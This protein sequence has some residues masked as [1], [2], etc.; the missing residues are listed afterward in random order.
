MSMLISKRLSNPTVMTIRV[1]RLRS[2]PCR[3][4]RRATVRPW[5]EG[6]RSGSIRGEASS[7]ILWCLGLDQ[8]CICR[9]NKTTE[10][11]RVPGCEMSHHQLVMG[12][13]DDGRGLVLRKCRLKMRMGPKRP[14]RLIKEGWGVDQHGTGK[15]ERFSRGSYSR[16]INKGTRVYAA[17]RRGMLPAKSQLKRVSCSVRRASRSTWVSCMNLCMPWTRFSSGK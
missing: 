5:V 13:V 1:V 7:D 14:I 12:R 6:S 15:S 9:L 3:R 16:K 4:L 2:R 17:R 10:S 11:S 8:K